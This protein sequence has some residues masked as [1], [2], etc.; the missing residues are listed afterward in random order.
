MHVKRP[1]NACKETYRL[2]E[3]FGLGTIRLTVGRH[4]TEEEVDTAA[5][6]LVEAANFLWDAQRVAQ[7]AQGQRETSRTLPS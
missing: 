6:A 5:A 1:T 3:D 2:P 7:N 4:T